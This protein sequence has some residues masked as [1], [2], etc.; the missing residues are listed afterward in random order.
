MTFLV[1][2]YLCLSVCVL[3][4]GSH[5]VD[6]GLL[7]FF[8]QESNPGQLKEPLEFQGLS[9]D[10][11]CV[12]QILCLFSVALAPNSHSFKEH[13]AVVLIY[14]GILFLFCLAW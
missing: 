1:A 6:L 13:S 12:R 4:L 11:P 9:P 3:V 10:Q 8:T 7:L 2:I 5:L 14:M